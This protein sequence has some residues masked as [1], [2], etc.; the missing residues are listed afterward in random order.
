MVKVEVS[1]ADEAKQS[2]SQLLRNKSLLHPS[3]SPPPSLFLSPSSSSLS[4]LCSSFHL[5]LD[6]AAHSFFNDTHCTRSPLPSSPPVSPASPPRAGF[7]YFHLVFMRS[8][9]LVL[10]SEVRQHFLCIYFLNRCTLK[11]AD[12]YSFYFRYI[13]TAG[14]SSGLFPLSPPTVSRCNVCLKLSVFFPL[15]PTQ[16]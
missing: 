8:F 5:N 6:L 2:Q 16:T 11:Q 10:P 9:T 15:L 13:L 12:Q 7:Q 3:L 4:L 1:R 14:V